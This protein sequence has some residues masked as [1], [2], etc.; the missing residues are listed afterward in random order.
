[1]NIKSVPADFEKGYVTSS[2][3]NLGAFNI[4]VTDVGR[5]NFEVLRKL[6]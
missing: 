4:D 2:R 1:M 6:L 3:S 5:S